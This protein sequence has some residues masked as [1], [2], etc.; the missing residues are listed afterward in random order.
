MTLRSARFAVAIFLVGAWHWADANRPITPP[1]SIDAELREAIS[2]AYGVVPI[3][4][5][6]VQDAAQV[7]LGRAL[8]FDKILSGNKDVACATCH[9]PQ[10]HLDD[11]LSLAIGTGGVGEG[12]TRTPR[13]GRQF[14]ARSAPSLW[15]DGRGLLYAVADGRVSG[16]RSGPFETPA[17]H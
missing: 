17:G 1:E 2:Q 11:G 7:A 9:L 3:A 15:N 10:Q 13:P 16:F 14:H 8:F 6:P 12:P 5:M 4:P